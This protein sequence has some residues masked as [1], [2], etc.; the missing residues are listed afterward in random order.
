M[1]IIGFNIK[2]ISADKKKPLKGK[3]DIKSNIDLKNITQENVSISDKSAIN[4][5]FAFTVGYEPKLAEIEILGNV[6]ALDEED[7]FKDI[8][9][10]WK[11]KKLNPE[12]KIP[13]FNFIMEKCNLKA[14]HLEEELS[15]PL[16]IP[17]P[18]LQSQPTSNN[19]PANYAG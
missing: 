9:K 6:V 5:E 10:E 12:I 18:K 17:L 11:K 2:K 16:H 3:I 14:L 15:L 13:L 7:K 19:N 1:R 4:F 8:L